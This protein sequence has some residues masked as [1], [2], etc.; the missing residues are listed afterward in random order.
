MSYLPPE[1]ILAMDN[2]E[3]GYVSTNVSTRSSHE[4]LVPGWDAVRLLERW[5]DPIHHARVRHS[6]RPPSSVSEFLGTVATTRLI[7]REDPPASPGGPPPP[8]HRPRRPQTPWHTPH[9]KI[10]PNPTRNL[11][12]LPKKARVWLRSVSRTDMWTFAIGS[13]PRR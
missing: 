11:H 13:G 10:C 1:G 9:P 3:L 4:R 7:F 2:H 8:L 5:S 12:R 6:F